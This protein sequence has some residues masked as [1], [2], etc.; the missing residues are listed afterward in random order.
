MATDRPTP[1]S[2][3]RREVRPYRPGDAAGIRAVMEASLATDAIP[4]FTALDI[5]RAIDRLPA[6]PDGTAVAEVDGVIVGYAMPRGDD[7]TV[8]PAH[9]RQ[10]H[11]RA[12]V[13]A[14]GAI[15]RRDG[16][17][18]LLLHVPSHLP[19]SVAFAEAMGFHYHSSLWLFE[20]PPGVPVEPPAFPA[21]YASRE[22]R[23]DDDLGPYVALMT[24]T[25]ADHPTPI[26]WTVDIVAHVH[27]LPGFR[28]DGVRVVTVDGRPDEL[29]GF[30]RAEV[31][32]EAGRSVGWIN[33][34]GVLPAHRGRGL[35]RELLRWGIAYL[36][37]AGAGPVQLAVEALNDRALE[38]YRRHGFEPRVEWPHWA[39]SIAAQAPL[40]DRRP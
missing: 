31:W 13:P 34:I 29:V 2:A 1:G 14:A 12:L 19:G 7:L 4:G 17:D 35:G 16:H 39:L 18:M 22:L 5:E 6:D 26:S 36:R 10:G 33:Q 37:D 40:V 20:L 24:A 21:G 9:R 15:A 23:P 11:G 8:H 3:I 30:S 27:G 38:L 28:H 32:Q 25:F